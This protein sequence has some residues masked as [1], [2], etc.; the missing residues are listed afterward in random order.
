[1]P[2]EQRVAR[3]VGTP[4]LGYRCLLD[5]QP[6]FRVPHALRNAEPV[7][8]SKDWIVNPLL[9]FSDTGICPDE[10]VRFSGAVAAPEPMVWVSDPVTSIVAPFVL[11]ELLEPIV[12]ELRPE[13]SLQTP[14]PAA[15]FS[16]LSAAGL[17]FDSAAVRERCA[18]WQEFI[19]QRAE[20]FKGGYANLGQTLHPF[21]LGAA[22][23]YF[24]SVIRR[25]QARYG[26][27]GS[28]RRWVLHN[29]PVARFIQHQLRPIVASI[30]R[31][32][33][34][35]SYVYLSSYENCARLPWH[36]DR[37]Q[38]EYTISLLIDYSP[39]PEFESPWPLLVGTEHGVLPIRQRLGD[40]FLY[41]GRRL[42]HA[43]EELPAGHTSTHLFVQ[44][45]DE[46]FSGPLS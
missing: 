41:R 24:R 2:R 18:Q 27:I 43:R 26:D 13:S 37:P 44:Y 30:T 22:R 39:E 29:E 23:T 1:V 17:I 14:L 35:P 34:K 31:V 6:D 46:S 10:T 36:V 11:G 9:R 5:A 40:A 45:V 25:G 21:T 20:E 7:A 16:L 19:Q 42:K 15:T 33:V 32:P 4:W 12:S 8:P 3:R 28:P 38:N